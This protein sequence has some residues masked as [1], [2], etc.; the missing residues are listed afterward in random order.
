MFFFVSGKIFGFQIVLLSLNLFSIDG[1][2]IYISTFL[3]KNPNWKIANYSNYQHKII[4]FT[5]EN[6]SENS[7]VFGDIKVGMKNNKFSTSVYYKPTFSGVFAS[8]KS[9]IPKTN[10]YNLLFTLLYRAPIIVWTFYQN[11]DKLKT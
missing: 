2:L 10:K 6:E 9:L 5:S 1:T 4:R 8:F 7:V 3:L 11:I